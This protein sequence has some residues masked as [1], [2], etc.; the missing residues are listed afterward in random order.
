MII[1]AVGLHVVSY[2]KQ[3]SIGG[4]IM[5]KKTLTRIQA[6]FLAMLMMFGAFSTTAFAAEPQNEENVVKGEVIKQEVLP[7]GKVATTVEYQ[8]NVSSEDSILEIPAEIT[9]IPRMW[10][11]TD[12]FSFESGDHFGNWRTFYDGNYL[13][14]EVIATGKSGYNKDQVVKVTLI[15]ELK[16]EL[17][18]AWGHTI[19]KSEDSKADWI[20]FIR[21]TKYKWHYTSDDVD[22]FHPVKVV[23]R[24]Y[25]WY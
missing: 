8:M 14:F 4:F 23:M 5:M 17:G 19:N 21:D 16:N 3:Q 22:S 2:T 12:P 24:Y 18:T 7:D 13:A 6:L 11:E 15:D 1:Y 10:D 9:A 20:R 25:T